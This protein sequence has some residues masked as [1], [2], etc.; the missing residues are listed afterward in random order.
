MKKWIQVISLIGVLILILL[1]PFGV[2]YLIPNPPNDYSQYDNYTCFGCDA[3][4]D[5]TILI[6]LGFVIPIVVLISVIIR[7]FP[8]REE[9]VI[10]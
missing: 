4:N 10:E 6:L 7:Y 1:M 3:P 2:P 5:P 8:K 9:D